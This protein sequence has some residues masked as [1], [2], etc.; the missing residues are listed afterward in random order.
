M[1]DSELR[2]HRRIDELKFALDRLLEL[3]QVKEAS[4]WIS[5]QDFCRNLSISERQM[6][7]LIGEGVFSSDCIK[8]VGTVK[9]P[10]YRFH[11][12]KATDAYLNRSRSV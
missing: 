6:Y 4:A 10:R 2:L 11:S 7:D 8:N 3:H 9:R 12:R 1:T 5:R